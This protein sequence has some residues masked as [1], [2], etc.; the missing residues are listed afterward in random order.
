[1]HDV[2]RWTVAR[3][4]SPDAVAGVLGVRRPYAVATVHRAENADMAE[5][6]DGIL[7]GLGLVA[8]DGLEVIMPLHP[9][10]RSRLIAPPPRGVHFIDPVGHADL[11]ALMT[12]SSLVLTDSGGLQKEAYWLGVLCVTLRDETEWR[13]TV[14]TG[15]NAT[16]G[17]DPDRILAAARRS[18][19]R[20]RPQLYGDGDA[21]SAIVDVLSGIAPG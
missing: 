3:A 6:L 18:V 10:T 9:R 13:E 5:R 16:V 11:V 17:A 4:P 15:W 2:L 21:G 20:A 7:Q 14:E 1:M 8:A 19:P 12:G